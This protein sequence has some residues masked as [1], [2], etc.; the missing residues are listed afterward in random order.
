MPLLLHHH[1]SPL[2]ISPRNGVTSN[3]TSP[4]TKAKRI[5]R[6]Q[7]IALL[8]RLVATDGAM[9]NILVVRVRS[10]VTRCLRIISRDMKTILRLAGMI[11]SSNRPISISTSSL[12][13]AVMVR[14]I[15]VKVKVV[16]IIR[17]RVRVV[18]MV[19]TTRD[20]R[21]RAVGDSGVVVLIQHGRC[22]CM[23]YPA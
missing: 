5:S 2:N 6:L 1:T 14:M 21:S 22:A 18:H 20:R 16:R 19:L 15:R 7:S 13:Q 3:P 4:R 23:G 9:A 8:C 10:P 17:V 12:H 11:N